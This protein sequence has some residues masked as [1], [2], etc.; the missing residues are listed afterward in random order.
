M[1]P[2]SPYYF[3]LMIA[4]LLT[5]SVSHGVAQTEPDPVLHLLSEPAQDIELDADQ[6][7]TI[8]PVT[9]NLTVVPRFPTQACQGGGGGC[10]A[11]VEVLEFNP[12]QNPIQ[13][14]SSE[15]LTVD[16]DSRGAWECQGKGS[17]GLNNT[18]WVSPNNN[19]RLPRGSAGFG[20][21]SVPEG[22]HTLELE[23]SNGTVTDSLTRQLEIVQVTAGDCTGRD[24]PSNLTRETSILRNN[25]GKTTEEWNDVFGSSAD[26]VSF[27]DGTTITQ[28]IRIDRNKYAQIDFTTVNM[29][30]GDS[31][32]FDLTSAVT[33]TDAEV[34]RMLFAISEC[35]GDFG[36]A[37]SD[38]CRRILRPDRPNGIFWAANSVAGANDCVL[39]P[40]TQYFLNIVPTTELPTTQDVDWSCNGET[41]SL[42]A[43]EASM[44]FQRD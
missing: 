6:P 27:P 32:F 31:G 38:N 10:D 15:Q 22:M 24:A 1:Q 30:Q 16:W 9:G 12:N 37:L 29:Q 3:R 17:P 34:G 33:S 2:T 36:A 23:C 8:D 43:C 25:P 26:P 41:T 44:R 35:P 5:A 4:G 7:V 13:R 19:P 28:I 21:S 18:A 14:F 39:A 42:N 20:L 11:M 40:D